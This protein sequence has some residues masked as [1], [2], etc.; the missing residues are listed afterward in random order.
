MEQG[1]YNGG[2]MK[3]LGRDGGK[4]V[5]MVGSNSFVESVLITYSED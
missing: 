4:T 2:F 5:M 1:D 3:P